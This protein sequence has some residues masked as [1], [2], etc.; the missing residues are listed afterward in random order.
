MKNKKPTPPP[1][2]TPQPQHSCTNCELPLN[3]NCTCEE[4]ANSVLEVPLFCHVCLT[5]HKVLI[6]CPQ[7]PKPKEGGLGWPYNR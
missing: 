1:N 6:N 2:P 4:C 5:M 7:K 3:L